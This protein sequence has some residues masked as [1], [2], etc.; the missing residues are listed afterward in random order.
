LAF[1]V[2]AQSGSHLTGWTASP[3]SSLLDVLTHPGLVFGDFFRRGTIG[4]LGHVHDG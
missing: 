1:V 4:R 3:I 2:F